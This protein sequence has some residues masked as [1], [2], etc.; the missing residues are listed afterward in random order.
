M[1][2]IV[3]KINYNPLWNLLKA[4]NLRKGDLCKMTGISPATV[5]RMGKCKHVTT[6]A[7]ERI[8]CALDCDLD[9]ILEIV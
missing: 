5:A 1:S 9:D 7:L 6:A 2:K 4:R 3:K 8:C